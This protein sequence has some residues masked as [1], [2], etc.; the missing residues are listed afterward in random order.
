MKIKKEYEHL[1]LTLN[2]NGQTFKYVLGELTS[3]ELED[4]TLKGIDLSKLIEPK[5][6]K[7]KGVTDG[8]RTIQ[9]TM[10]EQKGSNEDLS[11]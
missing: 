1:E 4:L 9:G 3:D 10:D 7:Y 5:K 8:G 6:K 11:I 2:W